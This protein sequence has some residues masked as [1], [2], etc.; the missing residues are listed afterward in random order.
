MNER[1]K[2]RSTY[3]IH[4]SRSDRITGSYL[5]PRFVQELRTTGSAK[6]TSH[7]EFGTPLHDIPIKRKKNFP[8]SLQGDTPSQG[9]NKLLTHATPRYGYLRTSQLSLSD[10]V[11]IHPYGSI[12]GQSRSFSLS[13]NPGLVHSVSLN[14]FPDVVSQ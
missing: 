5:H 1:G 9:A 2:G 7:K 12:V 14:H 3:I 10:H 11:R 4:V 8:S 13:R 6:K